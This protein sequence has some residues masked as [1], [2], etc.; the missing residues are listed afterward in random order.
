MARCKEC[1]EK[2]TQ[3]Y[4]LQKFCMVHDECIKRFAEQTRLKAWKE[5]KAKVK[6]ELMTLQDWIKI[7]QV[8]FNNFIRLRDKGKPCISCGKQIKENNCDAGHLWSAGG[9]YNVRFNELNVNAQCSRPCN[10]DKSGDVNNYRKGF[11]ER[12]GIDELNELD[13]IANITRNFTIEEIKQI[14]QTYK[15]KIK[16]LNERR[17]N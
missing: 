15:E 13:S 6:N 7:T 16:E 14:N 8:T 12:Y 10:K 4:M 1:K 17:D 11:I 5:K 3:K 2:F 9:H